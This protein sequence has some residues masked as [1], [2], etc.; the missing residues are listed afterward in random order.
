MVISYSDIK[1]CLL[2]FFKNN[3]QVG[4]G[5]SKKLAKRQAA[6]KLLAKLKMNPKFKEND[7]ENLSANIPIPH[8]VCKDKNRKTNNNYFVQMKHSTKPTIMKLLEKTPH[9]DEDTCDQLSHA[10]FEELAKEENIE[11]KFFRIEKNNSGKNKL[12][13]FRT[14]CLDNIIIIIKV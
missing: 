14:M 1:F 11:Y 12:F 10:M 3:F 7:S 9:Y 5:R 6:F 13:L 2:I 4:F 8:T